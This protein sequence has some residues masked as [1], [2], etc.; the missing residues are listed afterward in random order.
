MASSV[1][2]CP[3][4]VSGI[5]PK[6]LQIFKPNFTSN[7]FY[8]STLYLLGTDGAFYISYKAQK[9]YF[10]ILDFQILGHHSLLKLK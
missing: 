8:L 5:A 2:H 3:L 9:P 10:H 4:S 1:V 6:V 7:V